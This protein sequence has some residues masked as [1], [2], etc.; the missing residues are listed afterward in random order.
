VLGVTIYTDPIYII[1]DSNDGTLIASILISSS[2]ANS[3]WIKEF[4]CSFIDSINHLL[5]GGF[6]S[7]YGTNF[8]KVDYE[9]Y[10]IVIGVHIPYQFGSA[11]H[12]LPLV[13]KFDYINHYFYLGV[14]LITQAD[15]SILCG[16]YKF[17]TYLN[18]FGSIG[19]SVGSWSDN[20]ELSGISINGN[21]IATLIT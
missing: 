7:Y 12:S 14:R 1:L 3:Y 16:M 11:V 9:A 4:T 10:T 19:P 18:S 2:T 6:S 17:D 5:Y 21:N 8:V 15:D 13:Q 20:D